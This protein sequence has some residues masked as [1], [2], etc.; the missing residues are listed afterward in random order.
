[1]K[2]TL[3]TLI[4]VLLTGLLVISCPDP[5]NGD[6]SSGTHAH[7]RTPNIT[8]QPHGGSW[9]VSEDDAFTLTV[10]ASV[11]DGG[12]LSYQWYKNTVNTAAGGA[13]I[14][15]D[16]KTLTLAKGD[17]AFNGA[18]YF[19]VV[20]TNTNNAAAETK[21]AAATS[22]VA[23]V[24]VS[25]NLVNA[26]A[27]AITVQPTG[28][29][30]DV[31]DDDSFTITVTAHS[32]DEGTLSYQWY[33]NTTNTTTGGNPLQ[34]EDDAV[35]TIAK[36]GYT[37][38]GNHYFY[39]VIT[40]RINDNGDGGNKTA[41]VMS[42]AVKVTV[43]GNEVALPTK[44]SGFFQTEYQD[45]YMYTYNTDLSGYDYVDG[46]FIDAA[47][48]Q[49]GY[50]FD[51]SLEYGW[52]GTIVGHVPGADNSDISVL[53]VEIDWAEKN[54]QSMFADYITLPDTGKYF[55]YSYKNL[56]VSANETMVSTGAPYGDKMTGVATLA[57]A[58]DEYAAAGNGYF[59]SGGL[60]ID[61]GITP[62]GLANLA[63]DWASDFV[64]EGDYF[65]LIRGTGYTEFSDDEDEINGIYDDPDWDMSAAIGIIVDYT[66]PTQNSG[67]LYI[68]VIE[69]EFGFTF[70][71]YVAVAWKNK[72]GSS[73]DMM[74]GTEGKDTLAAVKAAYPNSSNTYFADNGFLSYEK[75]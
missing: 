8:G 35:L 26:M 40:N 53:I 19:Y 57:E 66:D 43:Y 68:Q 44:L 22:S 67:V 74:I 23:A 52:G 72:T 65:V 3:F 25:G 13:A 5:V 28:G 69:S 45:A 9:D 7:A 62:T 31:S 38:D 14:G 49:F 54:T 12:T 6:G 50:Y 71:S 41:T 18:Y 51:T 59:S 24:T 32:A 61:R 73:I 2:K 10:T 20:V 1:M 36:S 46:F 47:T 60:Y 39:V 70:K 75:Q 55:A 33:R 48:K 29:A 21:T 15:A 56:A 17:Y 58:V 11:T 64:A 42:N 37:T 34:N 63:G 4:A 27:P 30:W 16:D